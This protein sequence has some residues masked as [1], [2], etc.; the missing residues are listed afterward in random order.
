MMLK[1]EQR[2][3]ADKVVKAM[4]N[5]WPE[6]FESSEDREAWLADANAAILVVTAHMRGEDT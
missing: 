4:T 1:P 2:T 3:L 6:D 5:Y